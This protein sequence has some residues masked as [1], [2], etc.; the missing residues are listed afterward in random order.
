MMSPRDISTCRLLFHR[1]QDMSPSD[2]STCRLLF[3]RS[4]DM[5]PRRHIYLSIV[6]HRS[7]DMSPS[8]ISTCRLLTIGV[9]ICLLVT[10]LPVDC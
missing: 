8:D 2:I 7:Q 5:S 6:N 1:S 3:H 10:Y 4:Q 9:R